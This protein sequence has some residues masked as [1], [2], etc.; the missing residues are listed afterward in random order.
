MG[1]ER[2]GR[3]G[4]IGK[5]HSFR[6]AQ[7]SRRHRSYVFDQWFGTGSIDVDVL[8]FHDEYGSRDLRDEDMFAAPYT[9]EEMEALALRIR[10]RMEYFCYTQ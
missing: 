2:M 9:A 1:Q 3:E 6:K 7:Y 5:K 10:R 8:I 4:T